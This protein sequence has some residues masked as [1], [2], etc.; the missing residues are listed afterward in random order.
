MKIRWQPVVF[1]RHENCESAIWAPRTGGCSIFK[2]AKSILV[3]VANEWRC[4]PEIVNNVASHFEIKPAEV[5]EDVKDVVEELSR[6]GFIECIDDVETGWNN[7]VATRGE[8]GGCEDEGFPLDEFSIRHDLPIELHLDLTNSCT[9][10]CV[11]CYIPYNQKCFLPYEQGAKAIR[12]FREMNG[13]TVYISGGECLMHP[14]FSDICRLCVELNLNFIVLTNLTLCDSRMAEFLA[15]VNPQFVNVSLYGMNANVHDSITNLP[16][17]WRKT[18]SAIRLCQKSGVHCRIATPL[19][20]ANKNEFSALRDFASENHMHL[21]PSWDIVPRCNHDAENLDYACSATDLEEVMLAQKDIFREVIGDDD[22]GP[23]TKVCDIGQSR[24]YLS[25]EGNYYPCD[26]MHGYVLGNVRENTLSEIW[27]GEKLNYLRGLK[28]RDFG[29]CAQC[30]H[31]PWCK[32]CPAFNFNATGD[33]FKTIPEKCRVSEV[34]HR[35][36]GGR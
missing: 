23:N 14:Q 25:A 4:V 11:H 36:Y 17:S 20:K 2:D 24:M 18:M 12:E 34:I 8:T 9:E 19:L 28:N 1:V 15:E 27:H 6:Q 5:E 16:G 32:V 3:E 31:R 30:E 10:R 33:L 21:V 26:C 7:G 13:W 29:K 35:V 22:Q